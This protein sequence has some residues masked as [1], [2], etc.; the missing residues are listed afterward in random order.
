LQTNGQNV[1]I[2]TGVKGIAE[3][4]KDSDMI[5]VID[6][7]RA[8]STIITALENGASS[9]FPTM[10][11]REAK[12]LGKRISNSILAGE[13][14]GF[15]IPGFSL[16]NS[17]L[18]YTPGT[19]QGKNI[20]LTTSN[21]T[22]VLDSCRRLPSKTKVVIG[23]LL[24]AWALAEVS[25]K[26]LR[27]GDGEISI[28]QAGTR[29]RQSQDDC[30]CADVLHTMI[31]NKTER[32]LEPPVQTI[33]NMLLYTVLSATRHGKRL[34]EI[35]YGNDVRYC[36]QLNISNVVPELSRNSEGLLRITKGPDF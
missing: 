34:I 8:S 12:D 6:V 11:I 15:R 3:A 27:E 24:N 14:K 26:V 36:G 7:L 9:I 31:E 4:S 25:R 16:G 18:E 30:I 28:V 1:K 5:I 35:G 17:P 32:V 20:L 22:R 19:V 13:R 23:A 21:C 10:T 2:R 33:V 29:G